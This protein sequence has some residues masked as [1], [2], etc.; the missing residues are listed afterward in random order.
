VSVNIAAEWT[1]RA[2]RCADVLAILR[3]VIAG[4]LNDVVL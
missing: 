1:A 2:G 4:T 3:R